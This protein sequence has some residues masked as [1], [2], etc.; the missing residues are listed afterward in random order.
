[1]INPPG[2]IIERNCAWS[3]AVGGRIV[4][5][6]K[7]YL[8]IHFGWSSASECYDFESLSKQS[9]VNVTERQAETVLMSKRSQWVNVYTAGGGVG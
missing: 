1:M 7:F 8:F 2:D 4:T 6:T 3:T 9:R 5:L